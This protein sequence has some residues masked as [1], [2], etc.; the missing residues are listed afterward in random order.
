MQPLLRQWI[1]VYSLRRFSILLVL[2]LGLLIGQPTLLGLGF[3]SRWHDWLVSGLVLGGILSLCDQPRQRLL[4]IVAGSL[5]V[6]LTLGSSAI[7]GD[8]G[9]WILFFA[10][11]FQILFFF[12]SSMLIMASI[13]K[14]KQL[15]ADNIS[16]A[17]CGYLFIGVGWAVVY[18]LVDRFV[19]LS[20]SVNP[21]IMAELDTT[22]V[23]R[24]VLTY[25]SFITLLTIGYGDIV[26]LSPAAQTCV[27]VE[28]LM[29]QFYLAIFVAGL[30][31]QL[32]TRNKSSSNHT[33][34]SE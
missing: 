29:G 23:P 13:L 9:R 8:A 2:V 32:N 22:V 6:L 11:L 27:W 34:H 30:V 1:E 17:I 18:S 12:G 14:Q 16:G 28:G 31:N 25:F 26:P 4:V 33:P 19:P 21:L 20:F 3:A 24:Q 5:S 10:H 7:T 15:Q